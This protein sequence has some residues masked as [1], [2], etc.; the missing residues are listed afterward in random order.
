[1]WSSEKEN[2]LLVNWRI[3]WRKK[4]HLCVSRMK[5]EKSLFNCIS[6]KAQEEAAERA[7]S[8]K[9][10]CSRLQAPFCKSVSGMKQQESIFL[11]V[12][13]L[14]P[15]RRQQREQP[16][17]RQSAA[18]F[19]RSWAASWS[20]LNSFKKNWRRPKLQPIL[21]VLDL[22]KLGGFCLFF[23]LQVPR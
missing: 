12:S 5:K 3:E 23:G 16:Q 14:R 6:F 10:E 17:P 1:M 19:R 21:W 2:K 7:A 13:P 22:K 11:I 15:K 18:D 20:S 8:A 4:K 9:A